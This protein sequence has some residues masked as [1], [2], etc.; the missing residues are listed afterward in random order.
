MD[1]KFKV[2]ACAPVKSCLFYIAK[3]LLLYVEQYY[4]CCT[5]LNQNAQLQKE[6][7]FL[8][9]LLYFDVLL[10]REQTEGSRGWW[11]HSTDHC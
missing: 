10:E 4:V 1:R 2:R 5:L 9:D 11:K 7:P 3:S 6:V 8:V